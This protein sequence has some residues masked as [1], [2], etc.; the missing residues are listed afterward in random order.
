MKKPETITAPNL[1]N[2]TRKDTIKIL[3]IN[4]CVGLLFVF[5]SWNYAIL[6][7]NFLKYLSS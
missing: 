1:S 7:I 5:I 3:T 2:C 6:A 4:V